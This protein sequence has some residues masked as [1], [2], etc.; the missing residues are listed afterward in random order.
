M[1]L[2]TLLALNLRWII[3]DRILQ[4]LVAVSIFLMLLIPPMSALSMRQSQEMAVTM[5]LS[6]ISFSLLVF[7]ISLG[8]TIVWRDIERRYSYSVLSLPVNRSSYILAKFF[9]VALFLILAA[10]LTGVC[11]FIAISFTSM[12]Y[13]S[14]IPVQ[15]GMIAVAIFMDTLKSML[16]AALAILVTTVSTSFFMPFFTTISIFLA[17]SASQDVYEFVS[18]ASGAKMSVT[19]RFLSK[20]V[21][22]ILPNFSSFNFKLQAVYPIPF[23]PVQI[24]FVTLYFLV[25][26]ALVLSAALLIFSRRELT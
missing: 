17:G 18:S 1:N 25:Y 21:Y 20:V 10:I 14:P 19:V 7:A 15:W 3:R 26:T 13:P 24:S 12:Q 6:F 23:N 4:A 16:L 5:A 22:Y 9:S 2:T 8:S 11:S